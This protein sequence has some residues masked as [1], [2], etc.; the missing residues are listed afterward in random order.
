MSELKQ[1]HLVIIGSG[2]AGVAAAEAARKENPD[3]KISIVSS[4]QYLPYYRL[5]LAEVLAKPEQADKLY[6]HD[7]DWYAERCINLILDNSVAHLDPHAKKLTLQDG[8]AMSYDKLI[9]AAGSHSRLPQIPGQDRPGAYTLW[10]LE[11]AKKMSEAIAQKGMKSCAVIGGGLL[12]LEASWQLHQR[13]LEVTIIERGDHLMINQLNLEASEL[14]E[15][16]IDSLGIKLL[17]DADTASI[18]GPGE[19]GQMTGLSLKDGRKVECDAVLISIGVIANTDFAK[20]AGLAIG[21]RIKVDREMKTSAPDI[22]AAGDVCEV[23]EEGYWFGLWSISMAQ[24]KV[25]GTNAAGGFT[26]FDKVIPP[27]IVNTMGTRIV[28]QGHG[29][30]DTD[31]DYRQEVSKDPET[32]DYKGL[33][34]QGDA[35]TGF[36]LIGKPAGEMVSL[37]KELKNQ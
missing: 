25:A 2:I 33:A 27:Y 14:L 23:D 19:D 32:H 26:T 11:D 28:S 18:D 6:L 36:V 10:T 17:K 22:F 35:L 15:D 29:M 24:G 9:I 8:Q 31:A 3:L 1:E 5:R 4:D 30:K 7:S 37:Q 34:Y 13:G 12:G 20:E 16:Y 21:R